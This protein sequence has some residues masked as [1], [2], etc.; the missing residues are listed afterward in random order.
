MCSRAFKYN[1]PYLM[2]CVKYWKLND[3]LSI[4]YARNAVCHEQCTDLVAS[5]CVCTLRDFNIE[6]SH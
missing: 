3:T 1:Y 2:Q 5:T 4:R 6:L